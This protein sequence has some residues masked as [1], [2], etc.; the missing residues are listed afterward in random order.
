LQVQGVLT[1]R[2]TR[3]GDQMAFEADLVNVSDGSQIWGQRYVRPMT[4]VAALQEEVV[5][6]LSAKLRAKMTQVEKDRITLGA[7]ADSEAYQLYLQGRFYWN[8]RNKENLKRAI[9]SFQRAIEKDPKYALAYAGLSETYYVS[10]GYGL[11]QSKE[12]IPLAEAAAQQALKL[13]PNLGAAHTAMGAVRESFRDW[14]GAERE[15]KRAIELDPNDAYSHYFYSYGVLSPQQR[16]QEAVREMQR[17]LEL[18]PASLAINA[19]YGGVLTAARRYDE[20]KQQLVHAL[21]MEPNFPISNAR[22]RDWDEIQGDY[23]DARQR[24]I[25]VQPTFEKITVQP[26]KQGYWRA[27]LQWAQQQIQVSGE[28]FFLRIMSAVACAQL[29]DREKAF[30]WLQK[31]YDAR[32]DL[33][34]EFIHTPLLDSLHSDPRYAALLKNLDLAE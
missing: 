13:A 15:F 25:A 27:T 9:N 8:Q 4:Q 22:M 1:G 7:T 19:N 33:L 29:G 20:A 3:N 12:S 10:S 24:L 23:E 31:S 6:D 32:D 16:H 21:S 2:M 18:E 30:D 11:L 26:G 14:A 17:A 28:E 5:T 34:P